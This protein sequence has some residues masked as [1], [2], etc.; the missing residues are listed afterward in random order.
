LIRNGLNIIKTNGRRRNR[1]HGEGWRLD[2]AAALVELSY[3]LRKQEIVALCVPLFSPLSHGLRCCWTRLTSAYSAVGV[4][5][6]MIDQIT[7]HYRIIEK[8][9]AGGMGWSTYKAGQDR[10]LVK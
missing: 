4:H 8:L 9:G 5:L 1:N 3:D 10:R 2:F 7:S 6:P